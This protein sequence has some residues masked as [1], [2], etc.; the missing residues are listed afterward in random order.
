MDEIFLARERLAR[1][2]FTRGRLRWN[3]T[4]MYP[5]VYAPRSVAVD[6]GSRIRGAWLWSGRKAIVAGR[7]AA[8]LHGAKWIDAATPIELIGTRVRSPEGIAMRNERIGQDEVVEVDGMLATTPVRT[9]YDLSRHLP[10][11]LAVRH[12]DSLAAATG[13][14]AEDALA[15]VAS[16]PRARG[17]RRAETALGLMDGGAQ[18]PRETWLRLL[19]ID[20]GFPRPRTQIRV[21]DGRNSA[22]LD[23]GWEDVLI[24]ADY[25]G[26]WHQT[27]RQAFVYGIGRSEFV[28]RQG[29]LDLHVVKEHS[30][31]Y[32]VHRF[33]TAF[34]HRGQPLNLRRG[35]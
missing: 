35:R 6:L 19:F 7:A 9:A 34:E 5:G 24:G 33:A 20:A 4:S 30:A 25:D 28:E 11:E 21:T 2:E 22:Y 18:S 14:L 29:W 10:R 26:E 1:G 13:V 27:E 15:L 3:Y 12:L 8:H 31:A 32:I 23:M 17:L 16:Y